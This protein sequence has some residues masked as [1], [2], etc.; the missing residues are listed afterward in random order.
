MVVSQGALDS[1]KQIGLNLY[2]RKLW[3][4]LLSRGSATAGEL[5]SLAK[6]PHSRTYDVLESLSQKGFVMIET[7]KPLRY[8]AVSPREALERAKRSLKEN[9]N[10]MID[11]IA[12]FESSPVI[13]ELERV[14]KQ[15]VVLVEPGEM[16][17]SLKGKEAVHQQLETIFKNAKNNISILAT[18]DWLND[19]QTRHG[20]FLQ[21]ASNKGIKIRIAASYNK[22]SVPIIQKLKN[23]AEVRKVNKSDISGRFCI[24]DNSHVVMSLTDE[25]VH[26]TQDTAIWTQSEHVAGDVLGPMFNLL[27]QKLEPV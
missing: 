5:S 7:T 1:L 19:I 10:I 21:K 9:F 20:D 26:P 15:G 4:S 14:F 8:M 18:P 27:W 17:S 2:E 11:R 12:K 6:V 3:V 16:T 23:F 25:K 22:E 13:K 24:V